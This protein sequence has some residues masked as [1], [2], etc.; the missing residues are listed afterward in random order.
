MNARIVDTARFYDLL[1]RLAVRVDGLRGLA[2]CA[3][4][5][6]W[7]PR[8]VYF[9]L[10][11]GEPAP[12]R[13]SGHRVVRVGTHALVSGSQATLWRRLSQHRGSAR[14]RGG[15][16]AF[17]LADTG[18][19]RRRQVHWLDARDDELLAQLRVLNG[20]DADLAADATRLSNRLRDALTGVCPALERLLG[21]RLLHPGVRDL[22]TRHPVPEALAQAGRGRIIRKRS[23]R[24][25][26]A[27]ATAVAGALDAQTVVV[28]V[29]A[30]TGA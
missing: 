13:G 7:P 8:G 3:G 5:M 29:E 4:R 10:E 25:A 22:L 12:V 19:T 24:L 17:V 23:P 2:D 14:S 18:R 6:R 26:K 1:D 28:P 15:N 21:P 30:V 11:D 16:D 9:F 27:L 20:Y